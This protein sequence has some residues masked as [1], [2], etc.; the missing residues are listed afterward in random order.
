MGQCQ[1]PKANLSLLWAQI[2]TLW[3]CQAMA[4]IYYPEVTCN[5]VFVVV[6]VLFF[7]IDKHFYKTMFKKFISELKTIHSLDNSI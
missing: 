3:F 7:Q 6:V 1:G 2:P 5:W 4:Q